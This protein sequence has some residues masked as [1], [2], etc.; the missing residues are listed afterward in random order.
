MYDAVE[1]QETQTGLK[2]PACFFFFSFEGMIFIDDP[3]QDQQT[4]PAFI[5]HKHIHGFI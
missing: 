3:L 1:L 4:F 2:P 5:L